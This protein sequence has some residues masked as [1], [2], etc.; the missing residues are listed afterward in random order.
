MVECAELARAGRT[1]APFNGCAAVAGGGAAMGIVQPPIALD[2]TPKADAAPTFAGPV[3]V[4]DRDAAIAATPARDERPQP[5][6]HR[7]LPMRRVA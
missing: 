5:R 7:Q 2:P 4:Y 6:W 3:I 1:P